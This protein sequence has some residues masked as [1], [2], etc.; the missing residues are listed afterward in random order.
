MS[1][2]S[3]DQ[4]DNKTSSR[5]RSSLEKSDDH[6]DLEAEHPGEFKAEDVIYPEGGLRAWA[7]ALGAG[8]ALL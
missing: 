5:E 4:T 3:K 1:T 6:P 8:L 7:T 2:S